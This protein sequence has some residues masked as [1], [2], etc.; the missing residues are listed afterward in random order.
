MASNGLTLLGFDTATPACSAALWAH[1]MVTAWRRIETGGRHAEALVPMLRA[2]AA[3]G[4]IPLAAV[5]RFAV[6]VGPRLVH[7]YSDRPGDG[8]R[9]R[10]RLGSTVD[11]PLDARSSGRRRSSSRARRA[12]PCRARRRSGAS[13]RSALR[14][15]AERDSRTPGA[16]RGGVARSRGGGEDR[17][18]AHRGGHGT[19]GCAC[20]V[21]AGG[22][23]APGAGLA[24]ARCPRAWYTAPPPAPKREAVKLLPCGRSIC[25]KPAHGRGSAPTENRCMGERPSV[26]V[27]PI[28]AIRAGDLAFR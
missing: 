13:L 28:R 18:P 11:R 15:L 21:G 17:R 20:G 1:G 10:A 7:R 25:V 5:D 3:E 8:A 16:P 14:P 24:H 6:T 12:C 22:R 9:P 2:V 23:R 19:G 4:G 26:A 27:A